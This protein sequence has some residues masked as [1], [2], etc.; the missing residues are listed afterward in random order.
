MN[1]TW[2]FWSVRLPEGYSLET[3]KVAVELK[4]NIRRLVL[5]VDKAISRPT[6]LEIG[7]A[8][9][10][11]PGVAGFNITVTEID[12]ETVGMDVTIEGEQMSYEALVKAIE[13]TGAVVHSI[14]QLVAGTQ[15]VERVKR[16]R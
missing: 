13:K 6:I 15:V 1:A 5:D 14:D 7:D 2:Q 8:I 9:E 4:M 3:R 16:E 11:V 12:I 10:T